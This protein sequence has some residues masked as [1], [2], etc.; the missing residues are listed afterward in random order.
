MTGRDT[1]AAWY[2]EIH[3][4]YTDDVEVVPTVEAVGACRSPVLE[5]GAG[6]GRMTPAL[7]RASGQPVVAVDYSAGSLERLV[8]RCAGLPVLAVQADARVLPFADGA[9]DT[10]LA[11]ELYPMFRT[12][13]RAAFLEETARVMADDARAVI[14]TLHYNGVF[15][16][17]KLLG[18]H[19]A[20]ETEQIMG[21]DGYVIR[22]TA[23]EFRRE[24]GARFEIDRMW[25][26][27]NVPARS[28]AGLVGRVGGAG[29]EQRLM[30][31]FEGPG[32]RFDRAVGRTPLVAV[33]G[34][35]LT[36][37]VRKKR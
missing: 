27:R 8:Q 22:L 21:G 2:D 6:T 16:A 17:W 37:M 18:N 15:R 12:A 5:L 33:S 26:T 23:P 35:Y 25:G 1:Q 20:R 14:S 24:L 11:A 13:D 31:L 30:R 32:V 3:G 29:V 36:A 7:V 34:L 9:F 19:T 4:G 28:I 10:V